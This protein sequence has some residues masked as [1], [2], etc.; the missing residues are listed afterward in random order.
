MKTELLIQGERIPVKGSFKFTRQASD[1]GDV[2]TSNANYTNSFSLIRDAKAI[3]LLKGLSLKGSLSDIPYNKTESVL[4]VDDIPVIRNGWMTVKESAIDTF[5]TSV[6]SGSADFWK[7]IEGVTL[8]DIDLHE[9]EHDKTLSNID[10]NFDGPYFRYLI[11]D[12]GG[13]SFTETNIGRF[14]NVDH[15]IPSINE[16]YILDRIFEYI[17]MTYSLSVVIDTWLTYPKDTMSSTGFKDEMKL[18]GSGTFPKYSFPLD[19]AYY[20]PSLSIT[21]DSD[22]I[23]YSSAS[24]RL[25]VQENGVYRFSFETGRMEAEYSFTSDEGDHGRTLPINFRLIVNGTERKLPYEGVLNKGDRVILEFSSLTNPELVEFV[26]LQQYTL[27]DV[28]PLQLTNFELTVE[29]R[30]YT[31]ISFGNALEDISASDFVKY[32][33]MR[34]GLTLFSDEKEVQFLTINERL[35][36]ETQDLSRF[37]KARKKEK[38]TYSN[39]ALKNALRHKYVNDSESFNDGY[40]YSN[41]LNLDNLKTLYE[42]FVF[43]PNRDGSMQVFEGEAKQSNQDGDIEV[44]YKSIEGRLYSVKPGDLNDSPTFLYSEIEDDI[45]LVATGTYSEVDA[46]STTFKNYVDDYW[47]EIERLIQNAKL[48]TVEMDMSII[49]F[50]NIDLKKKVYLKQEAAFFLINKAV[51]SGGKNVE[52]ELIKI[53]G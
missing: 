24:S 9:A 20:R 31:E 48:L 28:G 1:I 44:T 45:L 38:Y 4:L 19:Q 23:D 5:K 8:A 21:L 53:D 29:Q 17:G 13:A 6:I 18:E 49:H 34:Y 2:S 26:D 33:M 27:V 10:N 30:E 51:F 40:I 43:S 42:S 52:L 7:A 12:Y 32:I 36:A 37:Y 16:K 47:P 50:M 11:G 22:H 15:Q 25:T 39:Y 41:N 3:R 14:V 46:T 35:Q